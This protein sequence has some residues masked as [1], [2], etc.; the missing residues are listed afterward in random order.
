MR[1]VLAQTGQYADCKAMTSDKNGPWVVTP[2]LGGSWTIEVN[3]NE[4]SLIITGFVSIARS[5][6]CI[7]NRKA[8][9]ELADPA[10]FEKIVGYLSGQLQI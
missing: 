4:V 5:P 7:G 9:I 8:S 3:S 6:T 2:R 1:M 10:L